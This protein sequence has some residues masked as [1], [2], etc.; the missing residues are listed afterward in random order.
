MKRLS[1][2]EIDGLWIKLRKENL[3]FANLCDKRDKIVELIDG[4]Q[5]SIIALNKE[6]EKYEIRVESAFTKEIENK[7]K[8]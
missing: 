7:M 2:N 5:I 8:F 1:Q 4:H 6:L 3:I